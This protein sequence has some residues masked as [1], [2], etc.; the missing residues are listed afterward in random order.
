MPSLDC[1][2]QAEVSIPQR[3]FGEFQLESDI[4]TV[5]SEIEFQS[6]KGILV[7]FNGITTLSTVASTLFQSLKG[8]LVNF[9]LAQISTKKYHH[10]FAVSIPQR[11]FGEFQVDTTLPVEQDNQFQSLKGILVNFKFV[12]VGAIVSCQSFQSLKGILVNFKRDISERTF[13]K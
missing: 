12:V 2:G 11:D 7:N 9:K 3:D 10:R 1:S 6:L 13:T 5:A 4:D 8:I